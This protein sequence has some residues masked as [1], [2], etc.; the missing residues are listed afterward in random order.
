[1]ADNTSEVR[2]TAAEPAEI[3]EKEREYVY[4]NRRYVGLRE[5]VWYVV[6]DMCQSFNIDSYSSRFITNILQVDLN[7]QT[8]INAVNGVW[9]IVNDIFTAAI[10]EKT[11]TRWGKFKPYLVALGIPGTIGTCLYW[12]LPA[13]F[14]GKGTRDSGKFITYFLLTVIREGAGTFRGIARTGMLATITPHPVDRTR[15]ITMAEFF[16]GFLG[17]KLP[18]QI[19]TII[20]DLIGRKVL[21]LSY[22]SVF[23][24]MGNFTSIVSGVAALIFC[25][26]TRERVMQ[27]I[28]TPSIVQG[29]KSILNNKPILLLTLSNTLSSLSVGGSKSD[30]FIDVLNFAS[31]TLVAGIPGAIINPFSYYLVPWFR[32]RFS[33]KTL[34]FL[35]EYTMD[36][37]K[38]PVYLVGMIGGKHNGLYK[39]VLPMFFAFAVQE[40]IYTVF[41]GLRRVIPNEMYNEA[42]D[43]CEWRNGYRTEAM[44]SV[45]KGLATKLAGLVSNLLSLQIKKYIGYD[46]TSYTRGEAQTD[47]TKH[48][49][50]VMC[51]I[52]PA[53][54]CLLGIIPIFFYDLSGEK[55]ERM[56]AELLKRREDAAKLAMTGD[57]AAMEE[58]AKQQMAVGEKKQKL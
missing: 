55:R 46:I 58:L 54:T 42:M 30:Y 52:I 43:Y 7:F 48:G 50:F 40:A 13:F 2:E 57:Q 29:I 51:T 23:M 12:L 24:F 21:N 44:T 38:I 15:L 36:L 10:V 45:A 27:S 22:T 39:K 53:L 9:D 32:R 11:R 17:E 20:L 18:E 4:E 35:G 34:Y 31:M 26:M 33:T 25:V 5:T 6:Y 16:S 8:I 1:M 14:K 37:T 3:G 28:E 41:Y 47:D 56:Y 19:M 49:L